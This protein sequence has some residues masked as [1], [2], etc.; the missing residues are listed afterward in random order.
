MREIAWL[1][2]KQTGGLCTATLEL[3]E[4]FLPELVSE[5]NFDRLGNNKWI[6]GEVEFKKRRKQEQRPGSMQL[7]FYCVQGTQ[8]TWA[9]QTVEVPAHH[10]KGWSQIR[11]W[12]WR[13][14]VSWKDGEEVESAY[15]NDG[16]GV[17]RVKRRTLGWH[18]GVCWGNWVD[19][20]TVN[21]DGKCKE[22]LPWGKMVSLDLLKLNCMW[23]YICPVRS[24]GEKEA[25]VMIRL[26]SSNNQE[27]YG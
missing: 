18:P 6:R 19:E 5:L 20:D 12:K 27:G 7:V 23:C 16:L 25:D 1:E 14:G 24:S 2:R 11:R 9:L 10:T 13:R 15:L 22:E 21:Q 4:W 3:R 17:G 8:V 26:F